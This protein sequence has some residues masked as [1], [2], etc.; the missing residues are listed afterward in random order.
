MRGAANQPRWTAV[1]SSRSARF[2]SCTQRMVVM[3]ARSAAAAR[4]ADR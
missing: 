3:P 1:R 4:V 2:C